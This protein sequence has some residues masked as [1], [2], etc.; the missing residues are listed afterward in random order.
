MVC[1]QG[2]AGSEGQVWSDVSDNGR[3]RVALS[4]R[5]FMPSIYIFDMQLS[6]SGLFDRGEGRS[7]RSAG[8]VAILGDFTWFPYCCALP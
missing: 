5:S 6:Q 2:L 4:E 7:L 3:I 8:C 1:Q